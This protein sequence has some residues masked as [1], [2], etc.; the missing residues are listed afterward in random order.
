MEA[1]VILSLAGQLLSLDPNGGEIE[2]RTVST[3]LG[4]D[5]SLA[6]YLPSHPRYRFLGWSDNSESTEPKKSV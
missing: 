6:T 5:I 4:E 1:E 3:E 2:T